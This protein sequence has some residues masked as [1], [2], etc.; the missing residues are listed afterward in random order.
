MTCSKTDG[1]SI[2]QRDHR[3]IKSMMPY[4][5]WFYKNYFQVK[6]QGWENIPATG[7]SLLVASHNGGIAAP[8]MFMAMYDWFVHFGIARPTYGLMHPT[9][10]KVNPNLADLAV[11]CGALQA[12]PKMAVAALRSKSD[13]LVYPGG[14]QDVFRLYSER[15]RIHLAGRTGFIKLALREEVPIVPIV[16]TGSHE[17]LIVIADFYEQL[18]TLH[19]WGL[20]WLFDVDPE[21]FPVYLGLPW[22]LSIGPLPNFPLPCSIRLKICPP[23]IFEKYGRLACCDREYVQQCYNLVHSRMQE[24]LDEL[25]TQSD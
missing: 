23:I 5:Q 3:V 18:K 2:G 11:K 13:L 4:W 17:T 20:P 15:H 1:W 12:H 7:G 9:I 22:G 25:I 8:D 16:S 21:V 6:S 24:S 10:W 19:Q 14:V